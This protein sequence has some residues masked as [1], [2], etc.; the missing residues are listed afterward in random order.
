[1]KEKLQ[2]LADEWRKEWDEVYDN[3]V[4]LRRTPEDMFKEIK[5]AATE[6]YLLSLSDR[7]NKLENI[8]EEDNDIQSNNEDS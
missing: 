4:E 5:I 2:A 3:L 8:L 1:M 6:A 7:I